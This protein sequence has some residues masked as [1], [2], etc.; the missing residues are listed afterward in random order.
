MANMRA[1]NIWMM[2]LSFSSRAVGKPQVSRELSVCRGPET[3]IAI[4][5][6]ISLLF[7]ASQSDCLFVSAAFQDDELSKNVLVFSRKGGVVLQHAQ[8]PEKYWKVNCITELEPYPWPDEQKEF[9][10]WVVSDLASVDV[11]C[12]MAPLKRITMELLNKV[13]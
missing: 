12:C 4:W 7:S 10:H 13:W 5:P 11:A 2:E 6:V 9:K 3:P 1:Q 8:L